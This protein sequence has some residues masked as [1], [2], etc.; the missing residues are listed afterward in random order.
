VQGTSLPV[1]A[2]WLN[3]SL[4]VNLKKK[5]TLDLELA[6]STKSLFTT[7]PIEPTYKCIG[8]SIVNLGLPNSIII[9]LI[10]RD[11]KFF[12][13]D[14]ATKILSGDVLYIMADNPESLELLSKCLGTTTI[15]S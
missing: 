14:G 3:L 13:S 10:T 11:N 7:I 1:L 2:K 9:A 4:P 15:L 6:W 12:V 5:S 8:K